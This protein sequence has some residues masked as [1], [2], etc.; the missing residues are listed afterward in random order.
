MPNYF[1][2]M[3]NLRQ[4]FTTYILLTFF[5][6]SNENDSKAKI[7][8]DQYEN[9]NYKVVHQYFTDTANLNEDYYY[10]EYYENGNIRIQGLENQGIRKGER[11]FYY[12]NGELQAK[13]NFENDIL[14]G[15]IKLYDQTGKTTALDTAKNGVLLFKNDKVVL[16]IREEFNSSEQRPLWID[17]LNLMMDSLKTI[18]KEK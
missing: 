10:Q 8:W 4:I 11:N 3:R 14:N 2:E 1:Q 9:G 15:P 7:I 17:L 18:L 13:M 5:A 16:F 6:C 12:N